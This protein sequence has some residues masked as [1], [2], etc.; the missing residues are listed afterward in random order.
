MLS[1]VRLLRHNIE[2]RFGKEC[3]GQYLTLTDPHLRSVMATKKVYWNRFQTRI[4]RNISFVCSK[5]RR[6]QLI[7]VR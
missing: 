4:D 2:A 5:L 3:L 1:W 7:H 6:A